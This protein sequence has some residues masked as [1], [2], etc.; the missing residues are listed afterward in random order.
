MHRERSTV[1]DRAL[2][3]VEK[4]VRECGIAGLTLGAVADEIGVSK[5]GLL[6]HYCSKDALVDAVLQRTA[7]FWRLAVA[8]A[9]GSGPP[10]SGRLARVLVETFLIDP[11]DWE[12]QCKRS[13]AAMMILLIQNPR[14]SN[15]LQS[16]YSELIQMLTDDGLPRGM[17]DCILA[18]IDGVWM[19][20]VTG[21]AEVDAVR[22]QAMR[23]RLLEWIAP[24]ENLAP[25]FQG[26]SR[27][28]G[29]E[30]SARRS[31]PEP[32]HHP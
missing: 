18:S 10:G 12:P 21:L 15:P 9:L 7:D 26:T 4:I 17:G 2:D 32:V 5:G 24:Y 13:A 30:P 6:H 29:S 14:L 3:A 27:A 20:W 23:D 31:I 11:N 19:Q 28:S 16:I 1:K 22:I 8:N 25:H